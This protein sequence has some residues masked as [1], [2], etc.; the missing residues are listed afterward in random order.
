VDV[1]VDSNIIL[2]VLTE[3]RTWFSWSSAALAREADT[4]NLIINPIIYSEISIRFATIEELEETLDPLVF[5][6]E[7]IPWEAA[8][9]AGKVFLKYKRRGGSRTM[10]LPDF[11][12]GA[13][14]LIAGIP[15]LTRDKKRYRRYFPNLHLIAP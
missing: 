8:F 11:F 4:S 7:P 5:R 15:L 13:H 9:L 12:I 2:D 1:L 14:A 10:P 3:D 6:K